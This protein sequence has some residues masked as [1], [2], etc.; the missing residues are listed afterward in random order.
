MPPANLEKDLADVTE[1]MNAAQDAAAKRE[2]QESAN[3]MRQRLD[4]YHEVCNQLDQV[5]AQ[6]AGLKMSWMW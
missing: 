5:D 3:A 2:Y 6:L 1:Q 4:K